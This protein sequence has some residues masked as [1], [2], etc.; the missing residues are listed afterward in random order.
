MRI[1]LDKRADRVVRREGVSRRDRLR[2]RRLRGAQ[3][4]MG[5]SGRRNRN[6]E[7][8][9]GQRMTQADAEFFE[10]MKREGF[11]GDDDP[12]GRLWHGVRHDVQDYERPDGS[13]LGVV[14]IPR[15]FA[16]EPMVS[17]ALRQDVLAGF[18]R[19]VFDLNSARLGDGD[20]VFGVGPADDRVWLKLTAPDAPDAV[21]LPRHREDWLR[22]L[23]AELGQWTLVYAM[24]A[25][26]GEGNTLG[27]DEL[28]DFYGAPRGSLCDAGDPDQIRMER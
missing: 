11:A 23:P 10:I 3:E 20:V 18:L 21:Q 28:E 4:E 9:R 7:N 14:I 5:M 24:C 25:V 27:S 19:P 26:A 16:S 17:C 12:V 8:A 22:I 13:H 15:D 6:Q 1:T 2:L